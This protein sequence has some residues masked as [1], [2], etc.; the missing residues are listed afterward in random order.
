MRGTK[1]YCSCTISTFSCLLDWK[2]MQ[3]RKQRT[4]LGVGRVAAFA[5]KSLYFVIL[6]N[7]QDQRIFGTES[8]ISKFKLY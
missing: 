2:L 4:K 7:C 6:E 1:L 5:L 3:K 8:F